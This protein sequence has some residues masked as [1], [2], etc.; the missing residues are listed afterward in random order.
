MSEVRGFITH[1]AP[2]FSLSNMSLHQRTLCTTV[3]YHVQNTTSAAT[4]SCRRQNANRWLGHS[5]VHGSCT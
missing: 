2:G 5:S 4:V 3:T 1:S